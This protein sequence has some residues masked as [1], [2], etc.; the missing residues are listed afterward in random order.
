MASAAMAQQ[1]ASI[2]TAHDGVVRLAKALTKNSDVVS[3]Q[4]SLSVKQ[5]RLAHRQRG[6]PAKDNRSLCTGPW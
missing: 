2:A 1:D 6:G 4:L 3:E 5:A